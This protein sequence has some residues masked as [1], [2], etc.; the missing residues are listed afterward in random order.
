MKNL[1]LAAPWYTYRNM[2]AAMFEGDP[3]VNVGTVVE[4]IEP[5]DYYFDLAVTNHE[6]FLALEKILKSEQQ[7]GNITLGIGVVDESAEASEAPD[8]DVFKIAFEQNPILKD[9]VVAEDPA[10]TK[11]AYIRFWPEVVQFFNDDQTDYNGNWNGLA[12]DIA[13][14]IFVNRRWDV[15]FCTADKRENAK[16]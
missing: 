14:E 9:V 2:V 12:E 10:Q 6:K 4:D 16:A 8:A 13:R 11:H 5:Y 15:Q 7:F 3:E 1:K